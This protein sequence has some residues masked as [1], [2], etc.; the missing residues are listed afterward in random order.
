MM[1]EVFMGI[2]FNLSFWYKLSDQTLWGAVIS[3]VG[4]LVMVLVNIFGIPRWGYMAC[5]LGGFAGYGVSILMS[6]CLEQKKYPVKYDMRTILGFFAL[7]L[8]LYF[9]YELLG[10]TSLAG[11][12]VNVLTA[13][14]LMAIG[15]VLIGIYCAATWKFIIKRARS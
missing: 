2:Y 7:A 8:V 6:Y 1:A 11:N 4:A 15:T 9:A 3:A 14:P 10:R 5:A 13:W 12:G